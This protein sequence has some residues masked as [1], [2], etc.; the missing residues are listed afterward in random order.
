MQIAQDQMGTG[1]LNLGANLA[2]G[3]MAGAAAAGLQ[4]LQRLVAEATPQLNQSEQAAVLRVLMQESPSAVREALDPSQS[5]ILRQ[6]IGRA[7]S[8]IGNY[9][10]QRATTMSGGLIGEIGSEEY[11]NR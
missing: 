7:A 4:A 9:T 10:R 1:A 6:K 5:Q 8:M 2:A 11:R 3:N